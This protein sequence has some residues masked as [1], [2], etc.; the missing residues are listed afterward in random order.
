MACANQRSSAVHAIPETREWSRLDCVAGELTKAIL[1]WPV[2]CTVRSIDE[3]HD[4]STTGDEQ[5]TKGPAISAGECAI[6]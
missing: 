5:S 3:K 4:Q 2:Q 1:R 6:G